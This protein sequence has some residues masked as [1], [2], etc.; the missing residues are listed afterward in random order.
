MELMC[1]QKKVGVLSKENVSGPF[2]EEWKKV[3]SEVSKDV[4]EVD[5][6]P[7]ISSALA[8]KDEN[9]LVSRNGHHKYYRTLLNHN[10][11]LCEAVPKRASP[12]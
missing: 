1:L 10:S 5:V 8:V 4:E 7:A 9:E 11:V 12:L 2:I 6:A 3:Y